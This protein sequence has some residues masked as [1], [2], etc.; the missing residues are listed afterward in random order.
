MITTRD[1]GAEAA[2]FHPVRLAVDAVLM[3]HAD[4]LHQTARDTVYSVD[5]QLGDSD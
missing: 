4:V 1:D 2:E 3:L 5:P